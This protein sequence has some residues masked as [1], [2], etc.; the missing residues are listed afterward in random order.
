M[1]SATAKGPPVQAPPVFV[2]LLG[3][4]RSLAGKN[5][6]TGAAILHG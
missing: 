6:I 5:E 3:E 1:R 2:E 4:E